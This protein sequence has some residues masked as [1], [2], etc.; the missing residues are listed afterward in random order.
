MS[1]PSAP[2]PRKPLPHPVEESKRSSR[3][4]RDVKETV[5]SDGSTSRSA[6]RELPRPL[7]TT[8]QRTTKDAAKEDNED[9]SRDGSSITPENTPSL[10]QPIES[11]ASSSKPR[12]FAPQVVGSSRRSRRNTSTSMETPD[13]DKTDYELLGSQGRVP[14][15]MRRKRP[16]LVPA[17][18]DNSPR[19]STDHV[20]QVPPE[21]KFSSSKLAEKL[22]RRHSFRIPDL[23]S[24]RSTSGTE[25]DST[26]SDVN[27]LTTTPS[28]ESDPVLRGSRRKRKK[29]YPVSARDSED[30]R[31]SGYL[32]N[33]AAMTAEKQLRDQAMAAYPNE[34]KYEHVDHYAGDRDSDEESDDAVHTGKLSVE[35]SGD[36]LNTASGHSGRRQRDSVAG[37]DMAEMRQHQ[38]K[39][40]H[41]R[42]Q[43]WLAKGEHHH[44]P[45][46]RNSFHQDLADGA[47]AHTSREIIGWQKDNDLNP[48]RKAASPPMA[49]KDL[50]FPKCT[51]PRQT[52]MDVHQYPGARN[53]SDRDQRKG[54]HT[55]LWTPGGGS[56]RKNSQSGLWMGVN[57]ASA[58]AAMAPPKAVQTGLFTPTNERSDPFGATATIVTSPSPHLKS[59]RKDSRQ[60][61]LPTPSTSPPIPTST[62]RDPLHHPTRPS[63]PLASEFPDDFITQVYNYLSLGY[64]TLARPYDD[65]LSRITSIPIERLRCDAPSAPSK[66]TPH[67][68][69]LR[70]TTPNLNANVF[71][72]NASL[73][74]G[75][76]GISHDFTTGT[77]IHTHSNLH[78]PPGGGNTLG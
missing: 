6:R 19:A 29:T 41:Q 7:E 64:H 39:L 25:D 43:A 40:E 16:D 27:S 10:P 69:P 59:S 33:L 54:Q 17:P 49:G 22:P 70:P 21:S 36:E 24:I 62:T 20:P 75:W 72:A 12:R 34:N 66:S 55:G 38:D 35:R 58:Q 28:N 2:S 65:E 3:V 1:P 67:H 14:L 18:P 52:R 47:P 13:D 57:A 23:P 53:V 71:G 37:W 15:H 44:E 61:Q 32:L 50:R 46:R 73:G 4:A 60:Q 9:T 48:M 45:H 51:S 63:S 26:A 56:S 42:Q 30:E 8:K 68:H 76:G 11:T 77:N 31:F 78:A 5:S 74:S